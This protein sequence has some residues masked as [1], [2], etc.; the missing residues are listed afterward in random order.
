MSTLTQTWSDVIIKYL[1]KAGVRSFC[2]APGSRS[3]PLV[4]SAANH[5]LA[6]THVHYD[7]RGLGFFALG[8]AQ[9]KH[10]PV[11]IIV[12]SGTALGNL[13]PAVMEA[14][15]SRTPLI[16]LTADRPFEDQ[17]TGANQTVNQSHFFGSFVSHFSLIPPPESSININMIKTTVSYAV[18]NAIQSQEPVHINAMF[19]A[20]L[21]AHDPVEETLE[22][23]IRFIHPRQTVDIEDFSFLLDPIHEA[24][25]GL[26]C[27]GSHTTEEDSKA[28]IALAKQLQ[29]PIIAD[30]SSCARQA[31][32]ENIIIHSSLIFKQSPV[33]CSPDC[34]LIFG[35]RFVSKEFKE[36]LEKLPLIPIIQISNH[37][38]RTDPTHRVRVRMNMSAELFCNALLPHINDQSPSELFGLLRNKST[39]IASHLHAM[40]QDLP[41][42]ETFFFSQLSRYLRQSHA[43]FF[44]NGLSIRAADHAFYPKS[45]MGPI[46]CNRGCSGIDGNIATIAGLAK[47]IDLPLLGFIGDQAFLHD[48]N[49]LPLLKNLP[50]TLVI[51]NNQGGRI[52]QHLPAHEDKANCEKFLINPNQ[53]GLDYSG[54]LYDISFSIAKTSQDF[55]DLLGE[56]SS[57]AR[58]IELII[59]PQSSFDSYQAFLSEIQKISPTK[60]VF[61]KMGMPKF[62]QLF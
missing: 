56:P 45:P 21:F 17:N 34:L 15:M 47:G 26:I 5:P 50:V 16:I 38:E 46:F 27:I 51:F 37:L 33:E 35:D 43:L 30:I 49:S 7:E 62:L 18:I 52:F 40:T 42:N 55:F 22:D 20:P 54:Q 29:W 23:N 12:T 44:G 41:L 1:I 9:A 8:L 58:I 19:R 10:A 3:T 25:R 53:Y 31:L 14:K 60:K 6:E 32:H 48:I 59:D 28:I 13:Y 2:I 4:F 11:C 36:W 61:E 39:Q 24:K 57:Q